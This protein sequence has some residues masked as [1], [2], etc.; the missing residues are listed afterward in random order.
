[1]RRIVCYMAGRSCLMKQEQRYDVI[2]P[3]ETGR[4][5]GKRFCHNLRRPS[6]RPIGQDYSFLNSPYTE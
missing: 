2:T 3:V 1:M 5:F 4:A 6:G